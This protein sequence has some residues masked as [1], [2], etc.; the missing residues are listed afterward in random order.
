MI[1][2]RLSDE[3]GHHNWWFPWPGAALVQQ[4]ADDGWHIAELSRSGKGEWHHDCDLADTAAVTALAAELL[5]ALAKR[6]W[7][8]VLFVN[9]AGYLQP[10]SSVQ[11]LTPEQ[12]RNSITVN[13]VSPMI[14]MAGFV[15]AFR[16]FSG[17]KTLVNLSSGAALKG[18]AGWSMYCASKAAA[19]NFIHAMVDEEQHQAER[20]T[21]VNY[22][23]G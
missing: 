12:I 21:A 1:W 8:E 4:L 2:R 22:D 9:N 14:L 11:R 7:D 13:Q 10:I 18:Y 20:F 16:R 3:T 17:R 6:S 15:T 19:E 23:P 5:P